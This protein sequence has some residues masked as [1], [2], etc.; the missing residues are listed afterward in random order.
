MQL[1][2]SKEAFKLIIPQIAW[3]LGESQW[4]SGMQSDKFC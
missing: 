1:T 2:R 3:N 4:E